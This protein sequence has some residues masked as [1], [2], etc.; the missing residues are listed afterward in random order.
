LSETYRNPCISIDEQ[1]ANVTAKVSLA[2]TINAEGRVGDVKPRRWNQMSHLLDSMTVTNIRPWTFAK[3]PLA[4]YKRTIVYDYEIDKSVPLDGPTQVTFD[5]PERVTIVA[6]G[7]SAQ[8]SNST[9][10]N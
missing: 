5:L 8:P 6:T 9:E 3:P 4:P 10:K 2:L 1:I 7:R